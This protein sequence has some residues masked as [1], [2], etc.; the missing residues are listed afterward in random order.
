MP[1]K[2]I[3][4][5]L[6]VRNLSSKIIKF[7]HAS[8]Y[9]PTKRNAFVNYAPD[10]PKGLGSRKNSIKPLLKTFFKRKQIGIK[11]VKKN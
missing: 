1:H 8:G 6:N 5:T 3:T 2:T 7:Y 9:P 10:L 4:L 11:L